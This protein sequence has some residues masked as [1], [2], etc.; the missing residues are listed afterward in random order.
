[1]E[2]S[3]LKLRIGIH[4]F[5]A[6]GP[7]ELVKEQLQAFKE[8][9]ASHTPA[10][11]EPLIRT[12]VGISVGAGTASAVG[13]DAP[14]ADA[15]PEMLQ[16]IMRVDDRVVSLTIRARTIDEAVLLLLYGQKMLRGNDSVTGAEVMEGLTA[17]GARVSR[18]DRLL[19]KAGDI[20][21]AIVL[22][23]GR[24]KRYRLTNAGAAKARAI[25]AELVATVA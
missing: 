10:A 4:E 20:G 6:D 11:P 24:A 8:L 2:N 25:A 15:A 23:V 1:M 7:P 5:E 14:P 18:V 16:R 12:A 17:T 9:I 13:V 19:E 3:K 22:G 21:D